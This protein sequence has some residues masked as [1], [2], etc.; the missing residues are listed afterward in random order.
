MYKPFAAALLALALVACGSSENGVHHP[1][2]TAATPV[3]PKQVTTDAQKAKRAEETRKTMPAALNPDPQ[4]D[5]AIDNRLGDHAAYKKTITDFQA[6]VAAHDVDTVAAL[7]RYPLTAEVDGQKVVIESVGRFR[8]FYPKL[9]TPATE[10]AIVK[11]HYGDTMVNGNGVLMGDGRTFFSGNCN[12][13]DCKNVEVKITSFQQSP[14][15]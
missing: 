8:Q 6:A 11:A 13:S 5:K 14:T 7:V 15:Q 9:M 3:G 4:I 1:D 12:G 2:E 10:Q